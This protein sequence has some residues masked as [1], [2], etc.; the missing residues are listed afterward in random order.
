[1][2]VVSADAVSDAVE[3]L[4][5]KANYTLT[6]D[7]T[8][9]I[10]CARERETNALAKQVLTRLID[11]VEAA[12]EIDVPVCQDTGMAVV[13]VYIGDRVYIDGNIIDAVNE[14]VRR[15]YVGGALRLSVVRD[16]LYDRVNTEDNTPAIVHVRP[17]EGDGVRIVAL[18]KGFGSENM[19][20]LKMFTPSATEA[21]IVG[22][23]LETV[24]KAGSN[25]CPPICVGVGIGGDFEQCATLAKECFTRPLDDKNKDERY[26]ALEERMLC[27]INKTGIGPQGFSGDTTA[28]SVKIATAP[29]HIAGLPVAV[30]INC[31][32]IRHA[33]TN[34]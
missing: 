25:P 27:E 10:A 16:P 22:F 8:D 19:S 7:V 29:T 23:V 31:H 9:C 33:E 4:F 20:A 30:N 15:A 32:V 26:A 17:V 12:K 1:M 13:F 5:V 6:S 21:D 2:R 3:Q 18:P 11:N 14:G 28:L 24:K 34:L